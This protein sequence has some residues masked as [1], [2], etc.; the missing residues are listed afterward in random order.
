M[1][2]AGLSG[3]SRPVRFDATVPFPGASAMPT[4]HESGGRRWVATDRQQHVGGHRGT[5]RRG[6]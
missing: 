6:G 1:A 5:K 2:T 4:C 3:E